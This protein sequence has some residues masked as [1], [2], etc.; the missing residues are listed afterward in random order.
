MKSLLTDNSRRRIRYGG[1]FQQGASKATKES[2]RISGRTL[3]YQRQPELSL[4]SS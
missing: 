3:A 2:R 4:L 1:Y